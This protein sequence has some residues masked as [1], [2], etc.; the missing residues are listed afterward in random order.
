MSHENETNTWLQYN[1][2]TKLQLLEN[3]YLNN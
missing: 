3:V 2:K 1:N